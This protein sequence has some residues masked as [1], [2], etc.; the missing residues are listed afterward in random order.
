MRK[1]NIFATYAAKPIKNVKTPIRRFDGE[2]E[3]VEPANENEVIRYAETEEQSD[4][5]AVLISI[6]NI[7]LILLILKVICLIRK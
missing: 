2:N 5:Y 3:E 1:P 4:A 6:R 7:L